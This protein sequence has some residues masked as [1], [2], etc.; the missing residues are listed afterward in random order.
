MIFDALMAMSRRL[1]RIAQA[2]SELG[3]GQP[4]AT[5]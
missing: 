1:A 3:A 2:I 4:F 5:W